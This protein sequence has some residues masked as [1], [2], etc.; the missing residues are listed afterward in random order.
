MDFVWSI[1]S[2]EKSLCE[3]LTASVFYSR[4]FWRRMSKPD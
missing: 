3:A 4:T 2:I 1:R